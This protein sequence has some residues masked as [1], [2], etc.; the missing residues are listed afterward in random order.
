MLGLLESHA[1]ARPTYEVCMP[2][3]MECLRKHAGWKGIPHRCTAPTPKER[4]CVE[5]QREKMTLERETVER[6]AEQARNLTINIKQVNKDPIIII[7][8]QV[9]NNS[10]MPVTFLNISSPLDPEAFGLGLFHIAPDNLPMVNFGSRVLPPRDSS[11]N[12][13]TYVE[14]GPGMTLYNTVTILAEESVDKE[15]WA[16]ILNVADRVEVQMKGKWHGIWAKTRD[17]AI[18]EA[19][20]SETW[21]ERDFGSFESNVIELEI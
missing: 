14:I 15:G 5:K 10:T 19:E 16:R 17:K 3:H 6:K 2:S 20:I 9:T 7:H 12:N 11:P 8:I 18:S 4:E 21:F 13:E 1:W